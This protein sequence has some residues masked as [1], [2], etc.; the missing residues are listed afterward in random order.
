[1]A[2][3]KGGP[4]HLKRTRLKICLPISNDLIKKKVYPNTIR[5]SRCSLVDNEE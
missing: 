3:I 4:S 5:H 2:Q 1:V